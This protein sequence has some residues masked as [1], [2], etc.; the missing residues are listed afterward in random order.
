MCENGKCVNI[1]GS[2]KCVCD[3][4]YR[5]G[6]DGKRCMDIDECMTQPCQHGT[7]FNS[8]GSFRCECHSGF[9]L[10]PDGRSCLGNNIKIII[11]FE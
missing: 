1:E 7:C 10:G 4:G 11:V 3:P 2:F 8:P 6:P 9:D 5:L